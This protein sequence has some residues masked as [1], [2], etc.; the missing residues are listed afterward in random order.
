MARRRDVRTLAVVPPA[1]DI[2]TLGPLATNCYLVRADRA[3]EEAIVV[4]PSG[5]A[6]EIRRG[7]ESLGA[8]C[9]AILVTLVAAVALLLGSL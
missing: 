7:L 5:A 6:T 9:V 4:D 2:L 3:A 1:V 8:R